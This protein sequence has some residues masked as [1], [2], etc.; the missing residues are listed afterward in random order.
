LVVGTFI[1]FYKQEK[2]ISILQNKYDSIKSETFIKD[3][4][5]MRYEY[6]ISED[7]SYN[8]ALKETE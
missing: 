8:K 2:T 5:I 4:K 1:G 3:L 7:T 6:I